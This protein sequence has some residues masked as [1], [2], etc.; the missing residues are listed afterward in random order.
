L[1]ASGYDSFTGPEGE[2]ANKQQCGDCDDYKRQGHNFCRM[3]GFHLAKGH[4]KHVRIATIY[5]TN[6]KF[7]GYCGGPKHKCECDRRGS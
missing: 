4:V 1:K 5:H 7:C 2:M 3:C 6:E